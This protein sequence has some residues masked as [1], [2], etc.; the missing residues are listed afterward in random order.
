[1]LAASSV[2]L[3]VEAGARGLNHISCPQKKYVLFVS[4]W[5]SLLFNAVIKFVK[6]FFLCLL[7]GSN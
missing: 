3:A 1:M 6:V 5:D 7:V 2:Q 4:L